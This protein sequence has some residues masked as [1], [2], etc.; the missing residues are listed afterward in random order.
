VRWGLLCIGGSATQGCVSGGGIVG[1]AGGGVRG[2]RGLGEGLNRGSRKGCQV[3][4]GG[5]S[6]GARV[7]GRMDT[8]QRKRPFALAGGIAGQR[9]LSDA[10]WPQIR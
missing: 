9:R 5:G 3:P 8:V 10:R 1:S 6:K 4:A 2:N 7:G